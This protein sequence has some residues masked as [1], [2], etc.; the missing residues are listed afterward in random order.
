MSLI[1]R[2]FAAKPDPRDE[3]RPLWRA[4]VAEARQPHWYRE[5]GVADTVA[6]RFDMVTAALALVLIRMEAAPAL[7][8]ASVYLTELFVEDMDGQ[9][10]E[11][12]VGDVVVGKRVGQLM[13]AMGGR[14]A[15]YREGLAGGD[16][17]L[18]AAV[19]R[20]VTFA[21]QGRCMPVA[22]GLRG[23]CDRLAR[24]TDDALLAGRIAP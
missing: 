7:A 16:D 3:L 24:T 22:Q 9:I 8:Q 15:A 14:I 2:L 12:G 5:G 4:V 21:S 11:F 10:R 13:G 6:G 23:L 1:D 19:D 17:A 20:N 18:C